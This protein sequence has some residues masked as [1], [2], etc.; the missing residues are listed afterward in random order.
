MIKIRAI[1]FDKDGTLLDFN[2]TWLPAYRRAA[3]YLQ[4]QYGEAADAARL[5]A[6]G[7]FIAEG[8]LWR[9]DSPLASSSNREIMEFWRGEIGCEF[10]PRVRAVLSELLAAGRVEMMPAVD[11]LPHVL[12]D[13][14]RF[15]ALGIATMDDLDNALN[16]IIDFGMY[17]LFEFICGG[18]SG[19]GEKPGPGMAVAFAQYH[20]LPCNQVA[21]VGDS[22]KDLQM[23]RAAG[24]GLNIGVLSGTSSAE[25]L[26]PF[27]DLILPDIGGLCEAL[28]PYNAWLRRDA[29]LRARGER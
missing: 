25:S 13:L 5:L 15:F 2:Q 26:E 27:A 3:E 17:R 11:D 29:Q 21:M 23:G 18:D 7:G 9:P 14:Q 20:N 8:E 22:P 4:T 1:L 6:R 19:F 12:A 24:V 28:M 10:T 16:M